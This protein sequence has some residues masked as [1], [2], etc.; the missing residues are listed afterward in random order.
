MVGS[1]LPHSGERPITNPPGFAHPEV[2]AVDPAGGSCVYPITDLESTD[3]P[4]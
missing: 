1:T 3:P 2:L 4:V